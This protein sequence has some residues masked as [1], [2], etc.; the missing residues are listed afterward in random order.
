MNT[1]EILSKLEVVTDPVE[2]DK[3]QKA[4]AEAEKLAKLEVNRQRVAQALEAAA[5]RSAKIVE[6]DDLARRL[7]VEYSNLGDIDDELFEHATAFVRLA[8]ERITRGF[9]LDGLHDASESL[10]KELGARAPVRKP[11][12]L[13]GGATVRPAWRQNPNFSTFARIWIQRVM[14]AMKPDGSIEKADIAAH[15][16]RSVTGVDDKITADFRDL[17]SLNHDA[18]L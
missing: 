9:T 1:A 3:L 4:L 14:D 15:G 6:L 12:A 13:F 16:R 8:R 18:S 7:A 5:A 11:Q 17:D 10:A 2:F